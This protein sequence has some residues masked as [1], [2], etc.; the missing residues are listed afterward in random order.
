MSELP[1]QPPPS[2]P[3]APGKPRRTRFEMPVELHDERVGEVIEA[4][5]DGPPERP[6]RVA[7]T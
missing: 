7:R 5:L 2:R 3:R 4:F 6:R 1:D